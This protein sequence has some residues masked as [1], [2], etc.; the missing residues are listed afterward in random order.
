MGRAAVRKAYAA[1]PPCGI[2]RYEAIIE[3]GEHFAACPICT[4]KNPVSNSEHID[5]CCTVCRQPIDQD[6]HEFIGPLFV[7]CKKGSS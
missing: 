7:Y 1:C 3:T 4:Q 5:G 2:T 6:W